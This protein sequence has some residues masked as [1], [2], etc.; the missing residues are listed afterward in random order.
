MASVAYTWPVTASAGLAPTAIQTKDRVVATITTVD[1]AAAS[2]PI[3]HNM[4]LSAAQ[5]ALGL[6]VVN[7]EPILAEANVSRPIVTAQS[8][9]GTVITSLSGTATAAC[10]VV[11]VHRPHTIG[12]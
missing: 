10:A 2:I 6:P 5:L 9:N 1:S 11:T 8:A 4:G 7:I 3:A 12:M